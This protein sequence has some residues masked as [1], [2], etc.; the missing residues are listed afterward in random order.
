[1]PQAFG[2][3]PQACCALRACILGGAAAPKFGGAL[4]VTSSVCVQRPFLPSGKGRA[5]RFALMSSGGAPA[6]RPQSSRGP[7]LP[8]PLRRSLPLG[9]SRPPQCSGLRF[10]SAERCPAYGGAFFSAAARPAPKR[11]KPPPG[12]GLGAYTPPR[13]GGQAAQTRRHSSPPPASA[14]CAAAAAVWGRAAT[15][16][17][18]GRALGL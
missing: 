15:A 11:R 5:F 13:S 17:R 6:P 10:A 18:G 9:R 14:L 16:C 1:M 2:A 12:A 7:A 4:F 3:A 8:A